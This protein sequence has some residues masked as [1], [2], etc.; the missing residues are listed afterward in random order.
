MR[1]YVS[2]TPVLSSG[3]VRSEADS[4]KTLRP[5]VNRMPLRR[6]RAVI[7]IAAPPIGYRNVPV[8]V[9]IFLDRRT[10]LERVPRQHDLG[11][12]SIDAARV[13]AGK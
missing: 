2:T 8:L 10:A 12:L 6:R 11:R 4:R 1:Q 5:I 9:F 3:A 7:A 13:V